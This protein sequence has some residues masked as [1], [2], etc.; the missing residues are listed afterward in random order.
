MSNYLG[1]IFR[2]I[3]IFLSLVMFWFLVSLGF[4]LIA[5]LID[6]NYFKLENIFYILGLI[7]FIR[8]FYPRYIFQ[9]K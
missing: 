7:L 2:V 1:T 6:T 5:S 8:I 3:G 9:D 4:V